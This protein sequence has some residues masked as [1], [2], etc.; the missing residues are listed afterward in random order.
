MKRVLVFVGLK[1]G[2]IIALAL[3]ARFVFYPVGTWAEPTYSWLAQTGIGC[4]LVIMFGGLATIVGLIIFAVI[5]ANW[6]WAKRIY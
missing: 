1:V 3:L 2:E 4:F 5:K 6:N